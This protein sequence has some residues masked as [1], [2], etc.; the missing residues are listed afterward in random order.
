MVDDLPTF[1]RFSWLA[2]ALAAAG[3]ANGGATGYAF[4][5]A[6]ASADGAAPV[7]D[8]SP[9][10][11]ADAADGGSPGADAASGADASSPSDAS[12]ATDTGS[13][14]TG[15][16]LPT[17]VVLF[18]GQGASAMLGDTWTFDGTTWAQLDVTGPA[19]RGAA[20]TTWGPG[21]A[22][23]GGYDIDVDP[24]VYFHDTWTF[25]GTSWSE[26]DPTGPSSRLDDVAYNASVATLGGKLVLL[27][28]DGDE[29]DAGPACDTWTWDGTTWTHIDGPTPPIWA[30]SSPMA[31][32]GGKLVM[33]GTP[34]GAQTWTFDGA[35]WT[36][37]DIPQPPPRVGAMATLGDKIVLF[38]GF[39]DE[40]PG[41]FYGDTWT[42]DGSAWTQLDIPGPSA[43]FGHGMAT[44]GNTVVVFG[45]EDSSYDLLDDTWVFDGTRWTQ[46]DLDGGP[47]VRRAVTMSGM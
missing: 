31:E 19:P 39:Y 24:D 41:T 8:A 17:R 16:C 40:S 38:G 34:N 47:S 33:F 2:L 9:A 4:S 6:D 13:G 18:G 27:A 28:Y 20:T 37:L 11:Y 46:L 12:A 14:C 1:G 43:R 36:Q 22:L 26:A 7:N 5:E 42:F 10:G 29:T 25:D 45:G 32:L 3:C 35:A 23:F 30:P 44:L 21:V 15:A